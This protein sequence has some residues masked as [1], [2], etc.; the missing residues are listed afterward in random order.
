MLRYQY[1]DYIENAAAAPTK[2]LRFFSYNGNFW[3]RAIGAT[4]KQILD[5]AAL[6]NPLYMD[7]GSLKVRL[8]GPAAVGNQSIVLTS[9]AIDTVQ[10]I[11]TT[12]SPSFTNLSLSGYLQ[13]SGTSGYVRF[14]AA[15]T[16]ASYTITLP[17]A[18]PGNNTF[19]KYNGTSYVWATIVENVNVS[20]QSTLTDIFTIDAS[21]TLI[22]TAGLT[23]GLIMWHN[24]T[25]W[26]TLAKP[27]SNKFLRNT[28]AGDVTWEDIPSPHDA[29]T[30]DASLADI[31]QLSTQQL[32]AK[33][34]L[35]AGDLVYYTG[36]KFTR[37]PRPTTGTQLL[38]NT[39]SGVLSWVDAP[40]S[41]SYWTRTGS[42]LTTA[43]AND[44]VHLSTSEQKLSFGTTKQFQIY[45]SSAGAANYGY[46]RMA[47]SIGSLLVHMYNTDYVFT[48]S[49]FTG[50]GTLGESISRWSTGY[51]TVADAT[52]FYSTTT[53]NNPSGLHIY[54]EKSSQYDSGLIRF[55]RLR[56]SG[57]ALV[58]GDWMGVVAWSN[59]NDFQVAGNQLSIHGIYA[60][61]GSYLEFYQGS[62]Y[63]LGW[64]S[65]RNINFNNAYSFPNSIGAA[66]K[67]LKVPLSG[68]LLEWGDASSPGLWEENQT[69][70]L[71]PISSTHRAIMLYDNSTNTLAHTDI[72]YPGHITLLKKYGTDPV[73]DDL[74]GRISWGGWNGTAYGT[75]F[76][77]SVEANGAWDLSNHNSTMVIQRFVHNGTSSKIAIDQNIELQGTSIYFS[78]ITGWQYIFPNSNG[79]ANQMMI[80]NGSG[81]LSWASLTSGASASDVFSLSGITLSAA[82]GLSTGN[83]IYYDTNKWTKLTT[84]TDGQFLK[85][86][87]GKPAWS[88]VSDLWTYSGGFLTPTTASHPINLDTNSGSSLRFTNSTTY[89]AHN[90]IP[91]LG[92]HVDYYKTAD[93]RV[94]VF[95]NEQAKIVYHYSASASSL[96]TFQYISRKRSA[97]ATIGHSIND[98][99]ASYSY[100]A[101]TSSGNY[102]WAAVVSIFASENWTTG[103]QGTNYLIR[104]N[105]NGQTNPSVRFGAYGAGYIDIRNSNSNLLHLEDGSSYYIGTGANFYF[106]NN[107][108]SK[109]AILYGLST[110]SATWLTAGTAGQVLAVKSDGTLEWI[111]SSGGTTYSA[112]DGIDISGGNVIS[113]DFNVTN[114]KITSTELNTIQDIASTSD[115]TFNSATLAAFAKFNDG[116]TVPNYITIGAPDT[117]NT[118]Y[119]IVLPDDPP[120]SGTYLKFDGTDYVWAAASGSSSLLF[121]Y[122]LWDNSGT[123]SLLYNSN[124]L[125]KNGSNQLDTIQDI[126]TTSNV[127]FA[128]LTAT[129]AVK[130]KGAGA[131]YISLKAGSGL[132]AAYDLV[133]PQASPSADTYLLFNGTGWVWEPMNTF[134]A[135]LLNTAGVVSLTYNTTNLKISSGTTL[136][137]IQDIATTSDVT[138][139]KVTN[140]EHVL[141][142]FT[143]GSVTLKTQNTGNNW[144][145]TF[146]NVAPTVANSFL[147]AAAGGALSWATLQIDSSVSSIFTLSGQ[148]F[149]AANNS[150]GDIL[151]Y[152]SSNGEWETLGAPATAASYYLRNTLGGS[153][154]WT[155]VPEITIGSGLVDV[156]ASSGHTLT[157]KAGIAIGT[158]MYH[159]GSKWTILGKPDADK[160]LQNSSSG[161]LTWVAQT[162][163]VNY[164][165]GDGIIINS[166]TISA[167][168]HS[169]GN[170]VFVDDSGK[171]KID[172]AQGIKTTSSPTFVN[173]TL[174]GYTQYNGAISGY[175][176]IQASAT[177]TSYTITLPD[178]APGTDTYLK[179]NGINYVWATVSAGS[180][181]KWTDNTTHIIPNDSR[182][183]YTSAG[184]RFIA[185][186]GYFYDGGS[187]NPVYFGTST[188]G[189]NVTLI[190]T[191]GSVYLTNSAVSVGLVGSSLYA[192][193]QTVDLG[194]AAYK[195]K[196]FHSMSATLYGS[197]A[198]VVLSVASG[199]SA[200]Y[201][202]YFPSANGVSGD[203]MMLNAGGELVWSQVAT[204]ISI[205]TTIAGL[206]A[207]TGQNIKLSASAQV[208]DIFYVRDNGGTSQITR[209]AAPA[210]ADL[211]DLTNSSSGT[212][213]YSKRLFTQSVG[214]PIIPI[215]GGGIQVLAGDAFISGDLW[216]YHSTGANYVTIQN[217]SENVNSSVY[218]TIWP[219]GSPINYKFTPSAFSGPT[220]TTVGT[221]SELFAGMYSKQFVLAPS[222]GAT[223]LT[224]AYAGNGTSYQLTWPASGPGGPMMLQSD[225]SGNLSWVTPP[226]GGSGLWQYSSIYTETGSEYYVNLIND[227]YNQ[228]VVEAYSDTL[229]PIYAF[230]RQR[231]ELADII[232]DDVLGSTKYYGLFNGNTYKFTEVISWFEAPGDT[233]RSVYQ[234]KTSLLDAL[235]AS[236]SINAL[237]L[238]D[239]RFII[240]SNTINI[241]GQIIN[242]G[243]TNTL[244]LPGNAQGAKTLYY[245]TSSAA[246][247]WYTISQVFNDTYG[248]VTLGA[249]LYRGDSGWA[250]YNP[251]SE[252]TNGYVLSW[253]TTTHAPSWVAASGSSS[254]WTQQSG[255]IEP[256]ASNDVYVSAGKKLVV[257]SLSIYQDNDMDYISS[258]SAD[259]MIIK[260]GNTAI[261]FESSYV[262]IGLKVVQDEGL[263]R[264]SITS[265]YQHDMSS[266]LYNDFAKIYHLE[267]YYSYKYD[268][269]GAPTNIKNAE[270]LYRRNIYTSY[271]SG[272]QHLSMI[273][274]Q[275]D[276]IMVDEA[277]S[278]N[279]AS[280]V[281]YSSALSGTTTLIK[282]FAINANS[283]VQIM[284]NASRTYTFGATALYPDT[285]STIDLGTSSLYWKNIFADKYFITSTQA[286]Y[287][288]GDGLI[289]ENS[290]AGEGIVIN[291]DV[292]TLSRDSYNNIIYNGTELYPSAS[293][294]IR[295]G[296]SSYWFAQVVAVDLT[297]RALNLFNATKTYKISFS[298]GTITQDYD[299]TL[300]TSL[301]SVSNQA[302]I[303]STS[304]VLIWASV[305]T[306]P[307]TAEGDII[308]GG[309]SGVPT[310]LAKSATNDYYLKSTSSGIVWAAVSGGS[311]PLSAKGDIYTRTSS[312]DERLAVGTNNYVLVA[313][314]TETVGLK[315]IEAPWD[316]KVSNVVYYNTDADYTLALTDAGAYRQHDVSNARDVIVPKNSD[317]AFAVG[318]VITIE[319]TNLGQITIAPVNGD[320]T[321]NKYGGLKTAG[322]YT[323][324]QLT[325]TDTNT[326]TVLGG[327]S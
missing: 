199:G 216:L 198:N 238:S 273:A 318:T 8:S 100:F 243:S 10:D 14:Q 154:S 241:A 306:N 228:V 193:D 2:G 92:Y 246:S 305:L 190:S 138:F 267:N 310:R 226:S 184:K 280:N 45:H 6:V 304:G 66:G 162:S 151:Y 300:P 175:A 94:E 296:T 311:S 150:H 158:I 285:D 244:Y 325:K 118:S 212:P 261:G 77:I 95:Q 242:K 83:I 123:V 54:R 160:V 120:A 279:S 129:T 252:P 19:L 121:S 65:A 205:D 165:A 215:S 21:Q 182:D 315:W 178:A 247:S 179:F 35:V 189:K 208:G 60:L 93:E 265:S 183:V 74:L 194:T 36:T 275:N 213:S 112:G 309:T 101:H 117:V 68:T 109:G 53:G 9:N 263:E 4:A 271:Y 168:L 169:N 142:G 264:H 180:G 145:L 114:L 319:Q 219:S 301:P 28:S 167:A 155:L 63:V 173:L 163:G 82:S 287:S 218:L 104:T 44:E 233:K 107:T 33:T 185:D 171:N 113:V 106:P 299:Y 314:S 170:L 26:T 181:S 209:L 245:A 3:K 130:L 15:A 307:M 128:N 76:T 274:Y 39:T 321:L 200:S 313:D 67:V 61:G 302:L 225:S 251:G 41:T 232:D 286:I 250:V 102:G 203:V 290:E 143:N 81:T 206:L 22:A 23:K 40:T 108:I 292:I 80:N 122:P 144:T 294:A 57:T 320:V 25:K 210:T 222:S 186:N 125:K 289:I 37:L 256:S 277:S 18:A 7:S 139:N 176:R 110:S 260:Y 146:P 164:S 38:Q 147:V 156:F 84:G 235:N 192:A 52:K 119:S 43:T 282:R 29:V 55:N 284:P 230:S 281:E 89:T 187:G 17:S 85:L 270:T 46:L 134:S 236:T 133:F 231:S 291:A 27:A 50:G 1:S 248:T 326:W 317:V 262:D 172:T 115:V 141:A 254:L 278:S 96:N 269:L 161:T 12:A 303:C 56:A 227:G 152:N 59:L 31:F 11:R 202:L 177:T 42:V 99:I 132:A 316:K 312:Q 149:T 197:S 58:D 20:V 136:N 237:E 137:T 217:R 62:T 211:Y 34:G 72:T 87:S 79:A 298:V 131:Y 268:S 224:H 166:N 259:G 153:L 148:T 323:I 135:P 258:A 234:I 78:G 86:I 111:T 220:G 90:I 71:K 266:T 116:Q 239:D 124:N 69:Y 257:D 49:S 223:R 140:K 157:T 98:Q 207:N 127:T 255:Y 283:T 126:A 105:Y 201:S 293:D 13:V 73:N 229:Y 5:E 97:G 272:G 297:G 188:A 30:L 249:L 276:V 91:A 103:N 327:V 324:I 70:F 64:N 195:W 75:A 308:I 24:G 295:I 196:S 191:A 214:N 159:D 88:N 174:N 288:S 32:Q 16:G 240:A 47:A 204:G 48:P 253:N 322:R 221:T 51:F